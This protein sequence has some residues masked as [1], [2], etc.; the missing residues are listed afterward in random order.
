M[1]VGRRA[2]RRRAPSLPILFG[3]AA[4][5]ATV[6]GFAPIGS[7]LLPFATFAVLVVLWQDATAPRDAAWLGFAFGLALFGTGVSWVYIALNTFGGM[8]PVLA[9]IATAVFCAYLALYPAAAGWLATKWTAQRS[10]PRALAAAGAW[11]LAEWARSWILSGFGWLSLGYSQLPASPLAGY[12][13]IG[14]VFAVTLAV[15]L[16]A[17]LLA[18]S[19]D[20]FAVAAMQRGVAMLAVIVVIGAGGAIAGRVNWTSPSGAPV[21][22]SL[23]QGDVAQDLKFDP[24]RYARTLE[25]KWNAAR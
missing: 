7:A 12:A 18:L 5:L 10:W 16:C 23:V 6:F 24:A 14:G 22:V 8:P 2:N 25:R 13:P 19:I 1:T 3:F 9:A 17:S 21:A 11:T 4:G 20:A 15:A